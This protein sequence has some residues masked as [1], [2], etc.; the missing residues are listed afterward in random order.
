M[1][2]TMVDIFCGA[3]GGSLG[4]RQAGFR[5]VGALD[6]DPAACNTYEYNLGF[7]PLCSD[8]GKITPRE[9]MR[10]FKL[11]RGDVTVLV[12]CPP[13]QGF[14]GARAYDSRDPRNA[15]IR[16]FSEWVRALRPEVVVFENVP[17]MLTR[18][19]RR[20]D[21]LIRLLEIERYE[22]TW[23]LLNAADY[24]VPQRRK[25]IIVVAPKSG[26]LKSPLSFATYNQRVVT[27]REA[28]A[29]L[30][31]LN[32]GEGCPEIPNHRARD[33]GTH[34]LNL[35]SRIPADG[36]SRA[37]VSRRYWLKCHRD[38]D[39][40]EDV[41]GRIQWDDVAPTMTCGCTDPTKGRFAH[42]EQ[43]RGITG[44]EA[45]RLQSF[46]DNF[47]FLK[48]Q[49]LQLNQ[50]SKRLPIPASA[51]GNLKDVDRQVGNAVPPR[52]AKMIAS[53]LRSRL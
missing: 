51:L 11:R 41:Y 26:N 52:L 12:G 6:N 3:G 37:D 22:P 48:G 13:C 53:R 40:H 14:S 7:A 19:R 38:S 29:N 42:P 2:L 34:A 9:F 4:F 47:V 1:S 28:I 23:E 49:G 43:N 8:I 32:A 31:T 18:S 15:M 39:G 30:P 50:L 46:P 17:G 24:G 36:G 35:L 5:I 33:L 10:H 25:R 45:A 27:V 21:K 16:I 44:R 20:F